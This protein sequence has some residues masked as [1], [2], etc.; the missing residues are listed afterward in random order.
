MADRS[1]LLRRVRIREDKSSPR[2]LPLSSRDLVALPRWG[3]MP[4][5]VIIIWTPCY[6]QRRDCILASLSWHNLVN[7]HGDRHREGEGDSA[8]VVYNQLAI[9]SFQGLTGRDYHIQIRCLTIPYIRTDSTEE[10]CPQFPC[11]RRLP[12][13]E[14]NLRPGIV[15]LQTVKASC[16]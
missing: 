3:C 7:G 13:E 8:K 15:F 1:P 14:W 11:F 12:E 5:S 4:R 10:S 9:G 2:S 6:W 16:A